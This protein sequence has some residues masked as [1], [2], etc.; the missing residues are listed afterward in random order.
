M[1]REE[2][3]WQGLKSQREKNVPHLHGALCV[4]D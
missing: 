4:D 2:G 1:K 3:H